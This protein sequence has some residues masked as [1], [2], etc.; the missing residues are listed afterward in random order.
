LRNCASL[1]KDREEL[2]PTNVPFANK[3]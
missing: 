2:N 3:I 1:S